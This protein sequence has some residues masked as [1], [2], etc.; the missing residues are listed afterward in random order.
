MPG[1]E[2]SGYV[3]ERPS[4]DDTPKRII[5]DAQAQ[6]EIRAFSELLKPLISP[7]APDK[8]K[9]YFENE[10]L[11]QASLTALSGLRTA[12]DELSFQASSV[13]PIA[14]LKHTRNNGYKALVGDLSTNRGLESWQR[15]DDRG[16][17]RQSVALFITKNLHQVIFRDQA[18]LIDIDSSLRPTEQEL[19][20]DWFQYLPH[21]DGT[22][23]YT[24]RHGGVSLIA[25]GSAAG[26]LL[27]ETG[28]QH[29]W[30]QYLNSSHS[31]ARRA[32]AHIS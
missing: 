9:P 27:R 11:S 2:N 28:L 18:G 17:T 32:Q 12:I 30:E 4:I 22:T 20:I 14:I 3:Y 25:V 16:S 31:P 13:L 29:T 10:H 19:P 26:P 15:K 8:W 24:V 21:I 5:S 6:H 7:W 23:D 1:Y